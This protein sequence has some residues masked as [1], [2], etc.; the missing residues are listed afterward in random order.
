MRTSS[1]CLG[2][3]PYDREDRHT[4]L[5]VLDGSTGG[6]LELQGHKYCLSRRKH[7]SAY[8]CG[9]TWMTALPSS[10]SLGLMIISKSIPSSSMTRF[11]AI[12]LQS[13]RIVGI[14]NNDKIQTLEVDPEIVRIEDLEFADYIEERS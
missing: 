14:W 7:A 5:E 4:A 11:K 1:Q 13:E 9:L 8:G 6:R 2:V 3:E 12:Q 10:V